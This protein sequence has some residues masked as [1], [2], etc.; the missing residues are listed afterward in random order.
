M[1]KLDTLANEYVAI[2]DM[3][4]DWME[5]ILMTVRTMNSGDKTPTSN[6]PHQPMMMSSPIPTQ[7]DEYYGNIQHRNNE[8]L[9]NNGTTN[10]SRSQCTPMARNRHETPSV[11]HPTDTLAHYLQ[12]ILQW[13]QQHIA[14]YLA[15]AEVACPWNVEPG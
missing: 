10:H 3:L 4:D 2:N 13:T 7:Q 9:E 1:E 15:L 5:K 8:K 6:T 14:S 12:P 11:H